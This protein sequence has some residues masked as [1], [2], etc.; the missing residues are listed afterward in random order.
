MMYPNPTFLAIAT[1]DKY[2]FVVLGVFYDRDG[3]SWKKLGARYAWQTVIWGVT[4]VHDC[5]GHT[6][7][8]CF[9]SSHWNHFSGLSQLM[10]IA[11][12]ILN[13]HG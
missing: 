10:S 6:S 11:P 8:I 9:G 7:L 5:P 1:L 4:G 3:I 2:P 12:L 13:I